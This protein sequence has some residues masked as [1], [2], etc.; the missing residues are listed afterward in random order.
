MK[1]SD[2]HILIDS[3]DR[4]DLASLT[5]VYDETS[6]LY[7]IEYIERIVR[8]SDYYKIWREYIKKTENATEDAIEKIDTKDYKKISLNIHHY[9]YS[10]YDIVLNIGISLIE[11]KGTTDVFEISKVVLQEHLLGNIAYV[12]LLVSDH[13]KYHSNLLC[14]EEEMVKGDYKTFEQ[15]YIKQ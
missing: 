11:E 3:L 14:I 13:Q 8:S 4:E 15:K 12:P 6:L 7:H 1:M 5:D 9:P 10:L 2:V